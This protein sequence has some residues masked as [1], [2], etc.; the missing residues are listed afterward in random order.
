MDK[1]KNIN[2]IRWILLM[3]VGML[4]FTLLYSIAQVPGVLAKGYVSQCNGSIIFAG[5]LLL[6]YI[7]WREIIERGD[8]D[9]LPIR[10]MLP[11]TCLGLTIGLIYFIVVVGVMMLCGVYSIKSVQFDLITQLPAFCLFLVVGVGEEI[12]F[13]GIL[14]RMIDRRWNTTVALVI[15]A[16]LFGLIH[17]WNDNATLWSSLA[18]AVEA[19]VLLGAA[20]KYSGTLWLP[21]GIHW[22]WNY[23]QGNIF[24]F[25][26]SG[27]SFGQ[28]IITPCISGGELLT[29]GAF[30]AEASLIS[31]VAGILLASWF[32]YK[33]YRRSIGSPA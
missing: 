27:N 24:G 9:D 4:V 15:S 2:P 30:G 26:V 16:L 12:I 11:D 28:S 5:F 29:G 6:I 19:G 20:Y 31:V 10:K 23:T 32:L 22:A 7:W 13:R 8:A 3:I 21:I 14:F 18:I 1:T 25:A 33:I 17:I